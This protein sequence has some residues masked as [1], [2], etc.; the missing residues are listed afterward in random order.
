MLGWKWGRG[1]ERIKVQPLFNDHPPTEGK[2]NGKALLSTMI[3][4]HIIGVTVKKG[5][6]CNQTSCSR[7]CL[8]KRR[9]RVTN[10]GRGGCSGVYRKEVRLDP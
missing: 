2:N 1:K 8:V 6:N 3:T 5:F 9:G 4:G 10:A 7:V